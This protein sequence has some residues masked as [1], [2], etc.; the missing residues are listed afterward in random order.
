MGKE[1]EILILLFIR[2]IRSSEEK[3]SSYGELETRNR[4][5]QENHATDCQ[6]IEDLRRTCGEETDRARQARIDELI[7]F[8]S[9]EESIPRL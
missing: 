4:L 3:I 1:R 7:V 2:S 8:A 5:F 9:R 6:E